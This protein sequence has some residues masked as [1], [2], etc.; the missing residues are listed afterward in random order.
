VNSERLNPVIGTRAFG[1]EAGRVAEFAAA[2]VRGSEAVGVATTPKH[3]PGHGHTH[4]DSH[5]ARPVA[6]VDRATLESRELVPF[7]AAFAAGAS[8]AMTAH[9]RYPVLDPENTATV[10]RAILTDLL[11]RE[12]RST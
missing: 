8:G 2:W 11:R 1:D 5:L 3:F 10:S 4:V 9:V 12:L 7:R 6:D